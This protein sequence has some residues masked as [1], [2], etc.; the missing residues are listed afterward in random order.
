MIEKGLYRND[1]I[2]L[3]FTEKVNFNDK[4]NRGEYIQNKFV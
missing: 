4:L 1:K 2:F 3:V